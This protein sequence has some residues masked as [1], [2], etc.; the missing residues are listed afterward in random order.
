MSLHFES[1][2]RVFRK[3]CRNAEL[4]SGM[5]S[6]NLARPAK[7]GELQPICAST[8]QILI[9]PYAAVR[10]GRSKSSASN[11]S[12]L[13]KLSFHWFSRLHTPM[14]NVEPYTLYFD[15]R[16]VKYGRITTCLPHRG[17]LLYA[18]KTSTRLR[19]NTSCGCLSADFRERSHDHRFTIIHTGFF[20]PSLAFATW[21]LRTPL[22]STMLSP[23][24]KANKGRMRSLV[25]FTLH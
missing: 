14:A 1:C 15:R 22:L 6:P 12:P 5:P 3:Q 23:S 16:T 10:N 8:P 18:T 11:A 7:M 4:R 13:R 2:T 21:P 9:R 17:Q 24:T 20:S 19:C 25:V